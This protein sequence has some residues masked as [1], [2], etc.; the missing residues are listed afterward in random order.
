M[1]KWM[2]WTSLSLAAMLAACNDDGLDA[3]TTVD[4]NFETGTDNWV[5]EFSEYDTTTVDSTL[6]MKFA[7]TRLPTGLDTSQHAFRIQSTN[8][9]DDMFMYLKKKVTGF[10]PNGTYL[11]QFDISLATNYPA[12]SMGVGGSPGSSVY[13]KIGASGKEPARKL[14]NTFYHFTLD[15]G[16]QSQAGADVLLL[17]DIANGRED[18][19][20]TL[21]KKTNSDKPITVRANANGEIWLFTGT[22]SGFE[23]LTVLYYDRIK[24][25]ITGQE[26]N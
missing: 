8:H 10:V 6:T 16:Q 14:Q 9:S 11:V 2:V 1:K 4:S 13:F 17:G 5:A 22:D 15:K 25:T 19:K 26:V 20:Y 21:I 23:G 3:I 24:V 7:Q 12:N 18:S